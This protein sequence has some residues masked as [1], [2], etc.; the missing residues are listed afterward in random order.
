MFG[1]GATTKVTVGRWFEKFRSGNFC[2]DNEPRGR[3]E[4]KIDDDVLKTAVEA[5]PSQSTRELAAKFHVSIP[6]I[7]HH[8]KK[9]AR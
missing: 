1:E 6:T 5:N 7:L 9:L 3:F 8:I 2:P 4:S